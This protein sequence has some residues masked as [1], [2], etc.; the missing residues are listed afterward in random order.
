MMEF[1][2]E[3]VNVLKAVHSFRKKAPS[4]SLTG[5]WARMPEDRT[6][7]SIYC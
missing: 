1:F 5:F 4:Q 2:A 3:R 6:A 7:T